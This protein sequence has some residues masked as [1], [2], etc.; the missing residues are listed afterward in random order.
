[1]K[2]K[3]LI[4]KLQECSPDAIVCIEAYDD[5]LANKVQEYVITESG[6]H[7]VYIADNLEY[8]DENIKGRRVRKGINMEIKYEIKGISLNADDLVDIHKYYEAAC[9]AEY[10]MENYNI[11][12]ES[13]AMHLGYEV[14]RLMDKYDY[15]EEYA[16][17]EALRKEGLIQ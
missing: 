8:I 1:M 17:D 2:V 15:D 4:D 14:R 6:E 13:E 9:T 3:E 16:I 11:T 7:H 12:D 10:I 5:C